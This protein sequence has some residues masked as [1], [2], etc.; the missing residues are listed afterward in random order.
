MFI[1]CVVLVPAVLIAVVGLAL[2]IAES[3][4]KDRKTDLIIPG[5][6][7]VVPLLL[8]VTSLDWEAEVLRLEHPSLVWPSVS[9]MLMLVFIHVLSRTKL[10]PARS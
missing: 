5:V 9:C 2:V 10:K 4:R 3:I 7:H 6:L 1:F 8:L